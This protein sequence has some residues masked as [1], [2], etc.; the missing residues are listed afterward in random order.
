MQ[1]DHEDENEV[2]WR[3]AVLTVKATKGEEVEVEVVL[4]ILNTNVPT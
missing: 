1:I 3:S 4:S 2:S